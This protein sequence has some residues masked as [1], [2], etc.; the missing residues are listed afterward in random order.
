MMCCM[1]LEPAHRP[2]AGQLLRQLGKLRRTASA[3]TVSTEGAG[4]RTT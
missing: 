3:D 1:S 4:A 2:T